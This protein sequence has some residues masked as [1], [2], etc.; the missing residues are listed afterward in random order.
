VKAPAL[1]EHKEL[2]EVVASDPKKLTDR[3]IT[4]S[5]L[6]LGVG[7]SSQIAMF[8]TL[9]FRIADVSESGVGTKLVGHSVSPSFIRTFARRGKSL[10][11]QV[12]DEKTKDGEELRLKIIA[13]TGSNVSQNTKRNLREAIQEEARKAVTEK[14]FDEVIQDVIYGRLSSKLFGKLK[15]ITKMRRVEVRKSERGEVFK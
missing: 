6:E 9:R 13:V 10:I 5:L 11:H 2:A 3:I 8:T 7:G 4:K 1:F 14:E 15:Q 12:V